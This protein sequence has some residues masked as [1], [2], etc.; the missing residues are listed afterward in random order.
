MTILLYLV[1]GFLAV[2]SLGIL[3]RMPRAAHNH[4]VEDYL[5]WG[6]FLFGACGAMVIT[7]WWPLG[8]AFLVA[9]VFTLLEVVRRLRRR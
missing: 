8:I 7:M 4:P 1:A 3:Y 6:T 2:S 9:C 5:V